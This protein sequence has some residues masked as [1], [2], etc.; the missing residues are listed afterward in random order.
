MLNHTEEKHLTICVKCGDMYNIPHRKQISGGRIH[1]KV[2]FVFLMM[3]YM[4]GFLS[5][6]MVAV[7]LATTAKEVY[8]KTTACFS[9]SNTRKIMCTR[10]IY[11]CNVQ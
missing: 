2:P 1:T 6:Y 11:C 4:Q 5:V 8:F 3:T 9:L 7:L 10:T